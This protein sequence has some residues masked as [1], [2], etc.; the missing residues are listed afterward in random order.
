VIC[1][2]CQAD[3]ALAKMRDMMMKL[4]LAVNEK[5]TRVCR[6]PEEKFDFEYTFGTMP[7]LLG[8]T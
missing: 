6:L 7:S 1:C 2:R 8:A 3:E 4:K 5:K